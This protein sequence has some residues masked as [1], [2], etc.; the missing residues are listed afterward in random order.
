MTDDDMAFLQQFAFKVDTHITNAA[1]DKLKYVFPGAGVSSLKVTKARAAFLA[2]FKPVPYHCCINSCCCFVRPHKDHQKCPYCNEPHYNNS[3]KPWKQFT[4]SPIIPRLVTLLRNPEYAKQMQYRGEHKPNSEE[5]S[6]IFD[7]VTYIAQ[8]SE[9]IV[10]DGRTLPHKFFE[11]LRDVALGLSTDGFAPFRHRKHTCWPL[12]LFNYN[13]PPN[14]RFHLK[15]ILCVAVIPGPKKPVDFDSF[16]WPLVEE[17]LQLE[18]GVRAYDPLQ[19]EL[20]K[21][22]AYLIRVFGDIPAVSMVMRMK[23]HNGFTPCHMCHIQGL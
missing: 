22:H 14:I 6:D 12:I 9:N 7:S 23:G 18:I 5:M 8:L 2:A 10:V 3:G 21:L 4:Y 11:D 13:L 1:F 15:H 17:L 19:S 16:L 20:F